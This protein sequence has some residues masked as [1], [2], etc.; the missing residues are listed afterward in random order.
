MIGKL[1]KVGML[2]AIVAIVVV[3]LPDLK[4]YLE[5]RNM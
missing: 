4:R 5:I 2:G 1:V 3:A